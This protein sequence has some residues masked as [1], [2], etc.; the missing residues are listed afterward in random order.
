MKINQF[1][2]FLGVGFLFVLQTLKIW[3]YP[4]FKVRISNIMIE[5]N[6]QKKNATFYEEPNYR[7]ANVTL[8]HIPDYFYITEV[9]DLENIVDKNSAPWYGLYRDGR[10][11]WTV[12]YKSLAVGYTKNFQTKKKKVTLS[13]EDYYRLTGCYFK[14]ESDVRLVSIEEEYVEYPVIQMEDFKLI[15]MEGFFGGVNP[16]YMCIIARG[17]YWII[18]HSSSGF[19]FSNSFLLSMDKTGADKFAYSHCFGECTKIEK[20]TIHFQAND[21]VVVTDTED[22][23]PQVPTNGAF[24]KAT[25]HLFYLLPKYY[26]LMG[27]HPDFKPFRQQFHASRKYKVKV[28]ALKLRSQNNTDGKVLATLSENEIVTSLEV[29]EY[30]FIDGISAPWLKVKTK[31]GQEGYAFGGYLGLVD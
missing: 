28:K 15:Q 11:V 23:P 25:D 31:N 24:Y 4:Q 17:Q 2:I 5:Q 7:S 19:G 9:E 1:K 27:N 22:T 14:E 30:Q 3:A 29:D 20:G 13:N 18:H 16:K 8:K 26:Y 12:E 6:Y 10:L 21:R